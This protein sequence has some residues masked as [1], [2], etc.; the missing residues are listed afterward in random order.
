MFTW[1]KTLMH[2]K[3]GTKEYEASTLSIVG[4][5]KQIVIFRWGK[6]G[7]FG[8]LDAQDSIGAREGDSMVHK[9]VAEN[10]KGGYSVLTY[11][12]IEADDESDLLR[13]GFAAYLPKLPR[14]I[15][16]LISPEFES[17]GRKNISASE[18]A[19]L[20]RQRQIQLEAQQ[21]LELE[22]QE[23]ISRDEEIRKIN[24]IWG[25]F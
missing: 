13:K 16:A 20:D 18:N 6:I 24:P 1:K 19:D 15:A 21:K 8:S 17:L 9:K 22:K 5:P 11:K 23:R 14:H 12:T 7:T 2:H 4:Q 25:M 10:L 3:Q